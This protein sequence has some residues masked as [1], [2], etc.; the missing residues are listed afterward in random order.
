MLAPEVES[1]AQRQALAR[2]GTR[3]TPIAS[4]AK[5]GEFSRL[6]SRRGQAILESLLVLLV[7]VAGFCF[8]FDFAYGAVA[9]LLLANGTARSARAAAVG[10]NSF[11]RLKALRVGIIPVAGKQLVPED[12]R[13]RGMDE[14]AYV[15]AYLQCKTEP[16]ARG[17]LDYERWHALSARVKR[18]EKMVTVET[19]LV[20]PQSMPWRLGQLL[21]VMPTASEATVRSVWSIENHAELYLEQ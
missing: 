13:V 20:L 14:L 16:D 11:H 15:R 4:C 9:R 17:M 2:R 19:A 3:F 7:L 6:S 21:G 1:P 5:R 12:K 10:F 8:F 18:S